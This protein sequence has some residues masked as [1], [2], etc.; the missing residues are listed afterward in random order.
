MPLRRIAFI[1]IPHIFA[2]S[3]ES[4][5]GRHLERLQDYPAE[6]SSKGAAKD[7]SH[8]QPKAD[9]RDPAKKDDPDDRMQDSCSNHPNN[10]PDD[11]T[12]DDHQ[13]VPLVI[14][15]GALSK[16]VV[17]D[18]SKALAGSPV[19]K[20]V[21]LKS[22][23]SLLD[24]IRVL[25]ADYEYVEKLDKNAAKRLKNYSPS[26]ESAGTGEYFLDLTGTKKLFG[27][28]IDTCGKI[29]RE[30]KENLGLT[31][32][33]GI[34]SSVLIARLASHVAGE[35]SVY[36][37]CENAEDLFLSAISV[38]LCPEVS[39]TVKK[40]LLSNYNIK[41]IG[42]LGMFT[43]S[44]LTCMFGKEGEVLYNCSRGI[45]R[46]RLIE[47]NT[48]KTLMKKLIVSS[49][50]NDDGIVRR[51]FFSMVLELCTKMREDCIFPRAF[52]IVF[53]YQDNYRHTFSGS[54]KNPSFFEK[55]LYQDLIIYVNRA[56]ERRTCVKKIILSF[57][58]FVPSSLQMSLFRDNSK[59]EKLTGTFDMIQKKFG[60][61]YIRYGG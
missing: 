22:I 46:D 28:E 14:V 44:D 10:D 12:K 2:E 40:A 54:L 58:R 47:K 23:A 31:A 41:S 43:K 5:R 9:Y 27:R 4:R 55:K 45:S 1:S 53:I 35:R 34:G 16:S 56:L 11:R 51:C 29:I 37:I 48:Q 61:K 21:F 19:R 42:E 49:E 38:K 7:I 20:G 59:L 57:S 32:S 18:H 6:N 52:H 50:D 25:P 26:V 30:F 39:S 13:G 15:S 8:D 17:I 60:K 33:I 36:D 3:E 24:K